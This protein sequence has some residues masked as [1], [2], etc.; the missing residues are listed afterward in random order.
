MISQGEGCPILA[1]NPRSDLTS[2]MA[3]RSFEL[4][5][6]MVNSHLSE[7]A[8]GFNKGPHIK[9]LPCLGHSF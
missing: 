7:L 2:W 1:S 4:T 9:H 5:Y 6:K 8:L 3:P